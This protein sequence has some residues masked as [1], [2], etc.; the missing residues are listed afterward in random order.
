M[1]SKKSLLARTFAKQEAILAIILVVYCVFV[2]IVN[3]AFFD[4]DVFFDI[5][6]SGTGMSILAMGCLVVLVSGGI[7]VSFT[8]IAISAGY[9]GIKI[10]IAYGIDNIFL[11][12]MIAGTLGVFLGFI[13]GMIIHFF[14]IPTLIAT[15]GTQNIFWGFLTIVGGTRFISA[16]V[17]PRS[18]LKFG[19]AKLFTMETASGT[20]GL[21]MFVVPLVLLSLITWLLLNK[22]V[23]GRS[24]YAMGSSSESAARAGINLLSTRLF[25][26]MYSGVLA[27]FM[28]IV[29]A[30]ETKSINPI[31]LVGDELTV[32]A[33]V[34]LGGA[35]LTG[36]T[37]TV[38]GTILGV[39]IITVLRTTLVLLGL[40]ASW[41]NFFVGLIILT[42]VA[43]TSYQVVRKNREHLIFTE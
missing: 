18:I 26:F 15:L 19:S 21:S 23:R 38:L 8:A 35:R 27:G 28:G 37:G 7:D 41:N 16:G 43:I 9:I 13:N 3:P 33:A 30:A 24:I 36:G 5:V 31:S 10:M 17:L 32:I 1:S 25:V 20:V 42:S 14:K 4:P 6:K 40:S 12:F 2:G 22:T 11:G 39:G 34:V 29:Y